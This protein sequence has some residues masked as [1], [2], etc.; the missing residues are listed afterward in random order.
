MDRGGGLIDLAVAGE[1]DD[2]DLRAL[3]GGNP[4]PAWVSM[5]LEREPS[6]FAGCRRYGDELAVVARVRGK[7]IG[8]YTCTTHRVHVDGV[9]GQI[10][11]LGGLRVHPAYRHRLRILHQGYA[12]IPRL[13]PRPLP[14]FWYTTIASDNAPARRLLEAGLADLPRYR[15]LGELVTLAIAR[16]ARPRNDR[17]ARH[18]RAT[19]ADALDDLCAAHNALAGQFQFSPALNAELARRTGATFHQAESDGRLVATMALWDQRADKQVVARAYR[20]PL[21]ALRPFYNICAGIAG[22]VALPA[23]GHALEQCYLS[24]LTAADPGETVDLVADALALS[25]APVLCFGL[26]AGHQALPALQRA[27]RPL[28]YRT[29]IYR[30]DFDPATPPPAISALPAQPEVALL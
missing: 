19:T 10:G 5:T 9:A 15:P 26:H 14:P 2:V 12:S 21:A 29:Q 25:P 30:V 23:P 8:M 7:A 4:M 27:F 1:T 6:F 13:A 11:Y 16:N 28:T 3:L 22:R 24:F 18:W 17:R 20:Q